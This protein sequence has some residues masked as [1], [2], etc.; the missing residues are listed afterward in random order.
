M[1]PKASAPSSLDCENATLQGKR[2]FTD[3]IR[4]VDLKMGRLSWV[5]WLGPVSFQEPL[6]AANLLQVEEAET[7]Q[8]D[9]KH[10]RSVRRAWPAAGSAD[11]AG[12][13]PGVLWP[14]E[15]EN[16]PGQWPGRTWDL[17]PPTTRTGSCNSLNEPGSRFSPEPPDKNP[18]QSQP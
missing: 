7:T 4:T 14:L 1:A 8:E 15:P 2:D 13:K 5:S 11:E 12:Y 17:S 10:I 16:D 18:A 9:I 6:K 3:V